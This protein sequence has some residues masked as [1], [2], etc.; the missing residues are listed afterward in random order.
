MRAVAQSDLSGEFWFH[1][2]ADGEYLGRTRENY[3]EFAFADGEEAGVVAY[4]TADDTFDPIANAPDGYPP[5]K[6]VRWHPSPDTDVAAY[7]IEENRDGSG[8][9]AI[10]RIPVTPGR[11]SYDLVTGVLVNQARYRWRI[12]P[13]DVAG[14]DGTDVEL[15][16]NLE[17]WRKPNAP[18]WDFTFDDVTQRV[19]FF[20]T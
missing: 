11:W 5:R 15:W 9:V 10:G 1:W 6:V 3:R 18:A 16:G 14:N 17:V 20:G 13:I 4:D 12:I 2:W 19:S 7:R 8:W